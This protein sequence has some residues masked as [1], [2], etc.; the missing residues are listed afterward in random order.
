MNEYFG[1]ELVITG[2]VKYIG[3]GEDPAENIYM[4][5]YARA[6]KEVYV[7]PERLSPEDAK[8]YKGTLPYCLNWCDPTTSVSDSLNSTNK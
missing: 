2:N 1:K 7:Q 6:L 8:I 3:E 4:K 5:A